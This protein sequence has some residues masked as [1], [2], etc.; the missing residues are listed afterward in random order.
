M[1]GAIND[2]RGTF[3]LKSLSS[4]FLS[5][6]LELPI[7]PLGLVIAF[8][9]AVIVLA[10]VLNRIMTSEVELTRKVVHIGAGN[11]ILIAWWFHIPAWM[12]IGA[13]AIAAIIALVSYFVPILPSINSVGRK[14]LGTFFYAVSMGILI[15]AFFPQ[16]P[17]Y[18]AIGILTMAWGDGM[19]ALIGQ[20]FGRHPYQ[21]FGSTKSWEGSLTMAAVSYFICWS[22][23]L[24]TQGHLWQIWL[25]SLLISAI[26]TSLE[27]ISK[28]GVDNLTVP[29]VSGGFSFLLVQAFIHS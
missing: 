21:V 28:L 1:S 19:A 13:A 17:A 5:V 15:A 2:K 22:I 6:T 23:L 7:F 20:D 12:G 24:V 29:L 18:A 25:I 9:A 8:L 3:I 26:A 27:A 16:A 10:E 14:S 11:V 4:L